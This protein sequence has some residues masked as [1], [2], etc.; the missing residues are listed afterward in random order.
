MYSVQELANLAG[1]SVRA[2]HH[3]DEL[4][5]LLP[6]RQKNGYRVY[7][8]AEL[9]RLQQILFFRELDFSLEEI[10]KILD[11]PNFNVRI[12]LSH[13]R[14]LIE[15]KRKRLAK[16]LKTIDRTIDKLNHEKTMSDQDLYVGLS[17]DE[18]EKYA[19]EAKQRWGN[20]DAWKQSQERYGKLSAAEKQKIGQ[21]GQDLMRQI[22]ACMSEGPK[23]EAVQGLIKQHYEG[24]RVFYDPSLEMYRG[25]ADM[26]VADPRFAAYYENFAPG[27]AQFMQAAMHEFCEQRV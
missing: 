4:Q 25:L 18:E 23:S 12:A 20:T 27:L 5:L 9:L 19:A 8:E 17:K 24:L 6:M 13:Q 14:E 15:L 26:Y 3:Y 21:A 2:L 22:V 1:V 7:G 16:L 11:N 10:K